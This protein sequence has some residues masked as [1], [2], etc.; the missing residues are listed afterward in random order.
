MKRAAIFD[1]VRI[2]LF[3]RIAAGERNAH[4]D[5]FRLARKTPKKY[6]QAAE[7]HAPDHFL[8]LGDGLR[9]F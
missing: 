7:A 3:N 9:G 2:I 4:T 5:L 1:F 8:F 6:D